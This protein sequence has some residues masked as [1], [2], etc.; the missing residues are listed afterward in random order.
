MIREILI[1]ISDELDGEPGVVATGGDAPLIVG[2]L[3]EIEEVITEL[4]LRGIDLIGRRN[5]SP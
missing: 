3:P 2:G 4:T 5:L 1:A